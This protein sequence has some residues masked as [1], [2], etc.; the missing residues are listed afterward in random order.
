MPIKE[1]NHN[2][3]L[4]EKDG[5]RNFFG[6]I[7]RSR[8]IETSSE[9]IL[10]WRDDIKG[11]NTLK[12]VGES[13]NYSSPT[14]VLYFMFEVMEAINSETYKT[15]VKALDNNFVPKTVDRSQFFCDESENVM[16][17]DTC[18]VAPANILTTLKEFDPE[19]HRLLAKK[20][21]G[22][23]NLALLGSINPYSVKFLAKM[24]KKEYQT[25]GWLDH[26]E[27]NEGILQM[28]HY[29]N[30]FSGPLEGTYNPLLIRPQTQTNLLE[31]A[32]NRAYQMPVYDAVFVDV[33]GTYIPNDS[34]L[35]SFN[36][37]LA[38]F[39]KPG[40]FLV[41]RDIG[42]KLV[43]SDKR[44]ITNIFPDFDRYIKWLNEFGFDSLN[45]ESIKTIL[46]DLWGDTG[47]S[48]INTINGIYKNSFLPLV[49]TGNYKIL[50][51]KNLAIKGISPDERFL[52]TVVV[53]RTK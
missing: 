20:L 28:F 21:I 34:L 24:L 15:N 23:N 47:A 37:N 11:L 36:Q 3:K 31:L 9:G 42:S 6:W 8:L 1:K 30:L 41:I 16:A 48:R 35:T 39:L 12:G 19:V 33:L 25:Q 14:A 10:T 17:I 18:D 43:P 44:E 13:L 2:L 27:I 50:T 5:L 40:G 4:S 7:R 29:M 51:N 45:E 53:Q 49:E 52:K 22:K 32:M 46:S 26:Y 38:Y